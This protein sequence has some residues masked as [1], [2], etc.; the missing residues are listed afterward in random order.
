MKHSVSSHH[1]VSVSYKYKAQ[2]YLQHRVHE[3]VLGNVDS[4]LQTVGLDAKTSYALRT[5]VD[6]L[7]NNASE[8][9][10]SPESPVVCHIHFYKDRFVF[11]I[12]DSGTG[13]SAIKT[14]AQLRKHISEKRLKSQRELGTR[15][16][17]IT[18]IVSGL[19][20]QLKFFKSRLGGIHVHFEKHLSSGEAQD[21]IGS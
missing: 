16:R 15:G 19:A 3:I 6:E 9:G 17:G 4:M 21:A 1:L 18:F 13:A 10:S 11:D 2:D 7:C 5:V 12:H 8:H 20:D 14:P